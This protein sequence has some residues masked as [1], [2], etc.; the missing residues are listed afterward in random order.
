M[1]TLARIL[2]CSLGSVKHHCG[3]YPL[4][5]QGVHFVYL[6][7]LFSEMDLREHECHA[8][9]RCKAAYGSCDRLN[10]CWF[11]V[12]HNSLLVLLTPIVGVTAKRNFLPLVLP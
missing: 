9:H 1:R 4:S 6:V 2:F 3:R 12:A 7:L 5:A 10:P 11:L 8:D